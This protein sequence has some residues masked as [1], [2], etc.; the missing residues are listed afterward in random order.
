MARVALGWEF[1]AEVCAS[2]HSARAC[3]PGAAAPAVFA[4]PLG[5]CAPRRPGSLSCDCQ[6]GAVSPPAAGSHCIPLNWVII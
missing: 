1:L 6:Q 3:H 5:P 4:A 2:I